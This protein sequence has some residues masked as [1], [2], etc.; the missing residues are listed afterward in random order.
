M[1]IRLCLILSF[2]K[3]TAI[4]KPWRFSSVTVELSHFTGEFRGKCSQL[5]RRKPTVGFG[6]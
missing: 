4:I 6:R 2:Q 3:E 1:L 5:L